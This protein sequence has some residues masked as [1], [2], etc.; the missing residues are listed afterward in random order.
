MDKQ[1]PL[2]KMPKP[3]KQGLMHTSPKSTPK[4]VRKNTK[5]P[6]IGKVASSRSRVSKS[7]Y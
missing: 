3:T 6:K 4:K 7:N 5:A 1:K 2:T